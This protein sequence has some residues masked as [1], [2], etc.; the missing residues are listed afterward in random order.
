MMRSFFIKCFLI[1][2]IGLFAFQYSGAQTVMVKATTDKQKVLLGEPFW[3]SLEAKYKGNSPLPLFK[4]DSLPHFEIVSKDSVQRLKEGDM[5]IVRQYIQLISFDSGKWVIPPQVLRPYVRTASVLVEVAYTQ[6]F[7]ATQP[8]HDIKDV[9]NV[10]D[11]NKNGWMV[12]AI[13]AGVLV[14]LLLIWQFFAKG[15]TKELVSEKKEPAYMIAQRKL[16]MLSQLDNQSRYNALVDI[17]REYLF[18]KKGIHSLQQTSHEVLDKIKGLYNP[19]R[20]KLVAQ[21]LLK[22]DFVK[23]AKHTPSDSEIKEAEI[24]I[25]N[26]IDFL[27]KEK[28]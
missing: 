9:K 14:S 4:I 6:P 21:V 17:F 22:S 26:A 18:N 5:N 15:K 1:V 19:D 8:F 2:C 25:V 10:P 12:W 3:L 7:D 20:Y 27:E 11:P 28:V 13:M 16:K 23:F 24:E